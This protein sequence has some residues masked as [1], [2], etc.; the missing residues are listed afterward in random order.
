VSSPS[1]STIINTTRPFGISDLPKLNA[2]PKYYDISKLEALEN[3]L[4]YIQDHPSDSWFSLLISRDLKN[5]DVFIQAGDINGSVVDIHNDGPLSETIIKYIQEN[6]VSLV[7][8]MKY[9]NIPMA[10]YYFSIEEGA[11]VLQ[12]FQTA[13][14][15]YASPG[16]VRDLFSA[17]VRTSNIRAI[18][19]MTR[20][21]IDSINLN[22]GTY[23][24]NILIKP[25]VFRIYDSDQDN[26]PFYV[27]IKR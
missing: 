9:V 3:V 16:M 19:P 17:I 12:D 5:Q 6:S 8:L 27:G 26:R 4:C 13:I 15:K 24:G 7:S 10:Q 22:Q 21:I 2:L 11:V 14:N 25:S 1:A 18:E 23:T 20:S